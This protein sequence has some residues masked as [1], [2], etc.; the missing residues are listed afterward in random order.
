MIPWDIAIFDF[1]YFHRIV[2][3]GFVVG[4][5][6]YTT[7]QLDSP[8]LQYFNFKVYFPISKSFIQINLSILCNKIPVRVAF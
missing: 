8:F 1:T 2:D 6:C 3:L 7:F 4:L 5:Y